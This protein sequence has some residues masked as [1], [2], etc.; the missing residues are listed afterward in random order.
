MKRGRRF[1]SDLMQVGLIRRVVRFHPLQFLLIL[2]VLVV[3]VLASISMIL[4]VWHPGFNFGLVLT[5]VVWWGL[6]IA[7][8]VVVGRGWCLMCPFGAFVDWLQRLSLWRK[9]TWSL[10]FNFVYPRRLRNLWL[11]IAFFVGFIFLDA[12]YGISN[13]PA[14]TGGLIVALILWGL[15]VAL[16][17][18]R[19]TF[20]RYQCPLTVFIGM[21]SMFAPFE[22]RRKDAEVCQQ[23]KTKNCFKGDEHFYGCP[24]LE[25]PGGGM[26][27]NRD[28]ILCTECIKA[29]PYENITMRLRGWGHDLWARK[30]G[31]PDESI[32]GVILAALVTV[33][34][35]F[36]VLFLPKLYLLVNPLLPAGTPPN[37]WPRLVSIGIIYLGG[38]AVALLLMYGFSHLSRIFGGDKSI[39]TRFFFTHFGYAA[40]PLGIMKFLSDILDHI[41]RTWGA[42]VDVTRALVQDFPLNRLMLEEVTVK[43]LMSAE[44]TYFLQTLMVGIGFGAS[45]YIAYK[46][47]G[48]AFPDKVIAFK[49]FLPMGAFIFILTMTALWA[50]SAAL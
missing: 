49:V 22:I 36:L 14:L 3:V 21:S 35:L 45:L 40:I 16:L 48:R 1:S 18:D 9:R 28:C 42:V 8:F 33:V 39:P 12:G 43:Q 34:S 23:C 19:R 47:A 5:W 11:G 15:W 50:L 13:S 41:F 20:C 4:G 10:G 2:P 37:D 38:I 46:L 26:D 27:T 24:M 31:L 17:Y 29:C 6:L 30:R 25:F 44:Q 7:L 32:A